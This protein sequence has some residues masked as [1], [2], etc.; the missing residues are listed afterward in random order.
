MI[1]TQTNYTDVTKTRL[2]GWFHD[3]DFILF[4]QQCLLRKM[5]AFVW[6]KIGAHGWESAKVKGNKTCLKKEQ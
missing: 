5:E 6:E 3:S 4:F 1:L 2:C